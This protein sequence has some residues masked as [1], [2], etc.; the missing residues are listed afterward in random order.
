MKNGLCPKCGS[1][2][3]RSGEFLAEKEGGYTGNRIPVTIALLN[4]AAWLD[5]YVCARCGYVESYI[6]DPKRLAEIAE[7]WPAVPTTPPGPSEDVWPLP[8]SAPTA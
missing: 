6:A 7:R 8:P 3:I 1:T 4:S 5:N 2:D